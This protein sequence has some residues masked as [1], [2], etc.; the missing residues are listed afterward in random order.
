MA[1]GFFMY[2]DIETGYYP[3][4]HHGLA[5]LMGAVNKDN[6]IHFFHVYQPEHLTEAKD[7]I[8]KNNWDFVGV[9]FTTNQR[10]YLWELFK[11]TDLSN[12]FVIGGGVH[13]TL[14]KENTFKEFPEFDAICVGE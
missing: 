3:G 6:D 5:Y 8:E 14:D 7:L 9:S 12:Q 1:K 13:P 10:K 4:L 11:T 2:F